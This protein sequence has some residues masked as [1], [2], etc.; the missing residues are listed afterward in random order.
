M[1][2]N[3]GCFSSDLIFDEKVICDSTKDIIY[4]RNF[5]IIL[6]RF[7]KKISEE[8]QELYLF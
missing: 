4:N 1:L 8:D 2:S 7:C 3:K 6:H 5:Q